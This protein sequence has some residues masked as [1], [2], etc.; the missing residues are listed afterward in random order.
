LRRFAAYF[1]FS[2][3]LRLEAT[4]LQQKVRQLL[5]PYLQ[6]KVRQLLTPYL[7]KKVRH[8]LTPYLQQNVRREGFV[9]GEVCHFWW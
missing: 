7:Q 2:T 9:E 8:L 6:Q 3:F 4:N 5:T 1:C